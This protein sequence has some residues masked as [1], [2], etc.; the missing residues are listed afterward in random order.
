MPS[1]KRLV[2]FVE[3][4]GD[5]DAVPVLVKHLL[6]AANGWSHLFLD[7]QPFVVGNVAALTKGDGKELVRFLKAAAKRPNLGAV[8]LVQD[9]DLP[10]I[11]GED[12][13]AARFGS[14]M[15]EW[16]KI[17]GAGVGF[18]VA[19]VFACQEYESWMLACV[20]RL[21]GRE[22]P[23]K[24]PGVKPG[25]PSPGGDLEKSPRDAKGW[26]DQHL[27]AGCKPTRD[28]KLFTQLMLDH[29]EVIRQR[30]LRSFLRLENALSQL[31]AA[32]VAGTFVVTPVAHASGSEI[33]DNKGKRTT[34]VVP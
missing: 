8:L 22:L 27:D 12:F 20:D 3:G 28:Q 16:A 10:R 1:P 21:A 17:A 15:S 2:L 14:R 25:T 30:P 5:R 11:R 9:G 19:T 33:R 31:V 18:S 32:A 13:C 7:E 6:T 23:D 29:L 4:A 26:L 34:N 24:R